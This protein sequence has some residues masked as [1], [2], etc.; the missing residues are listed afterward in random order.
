MRSR[1]NRHHH[2][3]HFELSSSQFELQV[4]SKIELLTIILGVVC[5]PERTLVPFDTFNQLNEMLRG[6]RIDRSIPFSSYEKEL[7][8]WNSMRKCLESLCTKPSDEQI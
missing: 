6:R 5:V 8:F 4:Y 1:H 2:F 7:I 3:G